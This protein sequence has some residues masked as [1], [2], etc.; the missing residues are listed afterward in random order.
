MF[1]GK[2]SRSVLGI[3]LCAGSLT[4]LAATPSVL[5]ADGQAAGRVVK[6]I[7]KSRLPNYYADVVTEKQ[8]DEIYKIQEAYKPKID[9]LKTQLEALNKEMNE[10]ITAVLTAEQKKKIADAADAAKAKRAKEEKPAET[11]KPAEKP[12]KKAA[13]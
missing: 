11:A 10:K 9:A 7:R 12:E 5:A 3:A 2:I 1:H 6:K 8:R 4:L 13:K